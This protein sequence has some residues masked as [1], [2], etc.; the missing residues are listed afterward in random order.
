MRR[1]RFLVIAF[2]AA[3]IALSPAASTRAGAPIPVDVEL[4]LAVDISYSM[5]FDELALQREGYI[6]ALT[7]KEFIDALRS[8]AHLRTNLLLGLWV[9]KTKQWFLW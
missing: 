6:T 9:L 3:L 7:S 1:V 2:T 5:D 8:G 4:V